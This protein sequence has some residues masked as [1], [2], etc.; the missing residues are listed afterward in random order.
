MLLILLAYFGGVLTILSA[1]NLPILP[2][3]FGRADQSFR[4]NGLPILTGSPVRFRVTID[5]KAPGN[6]HGVDSDAV[7]FG[8]VTD[9]RL[10]SAREA[11]G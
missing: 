10:L 5:D 3:V 7:G 4:R 6:N 11:A 2:F 1:C 9:N 8:I